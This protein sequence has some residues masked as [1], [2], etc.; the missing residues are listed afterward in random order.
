MVKKGDKEN[1][2]ETSK[3]II[4][5]MVAMSDKAQANVLMSFFKTG[6]GQYGEGDRF[7][8]IRVPQTREVVKGVDHSISIG[9]I[10]E[11]LV[12]EWPML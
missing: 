2:M 3:E 12:N 4:N 5:C 8:G 7:L 6:K 10:H 1:S 9:E 11:L